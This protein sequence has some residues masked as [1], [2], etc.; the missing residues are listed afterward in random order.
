MPAVLYASGWPPALVTIS[1][2]APARRRWSSRAEYR[3]PSRSSDRSSAMRCVRSRISRMRR[4][5][6]ARDRPSA[7]VRPSRT[8][9]WNQLSM[10]RVRNSTENVNTSRSGAT[11]S[12]LNIRIVRPR[13]R[14]PGT[15]R[16]QSRMK[17]VNR[18]PISASSTTTPAM[19]ISRIHGCSCPKRCDPS[20]VTASS[21]SATTQTTMPTPTAI[22][23]QRR[24]MAAHSRRTSRCCATS[25]SR[26]AVS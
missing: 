8:S 14:E 17:S 1:S 3:L 7:S 12:P 4:S 18:L 20:A 10:P 11:A 19:L 15:W 24:I 16:R 6:A 23:N 2:S 26:T 13:S 9:A 5:S 25:S 21:A 22:G